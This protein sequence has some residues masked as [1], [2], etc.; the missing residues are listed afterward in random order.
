MKD[1][2]AYDAGYHPAAPVVP[3]GLSPSGIDTVHQQLTA[4]LDTGADATMIPL[5]VLNEAGCRYVAQK[6]LRGVIG[7]ATV[8]LYLAA[9][10]IAGTTVHG[11]RIVAMQG[12]S[13]AILGRDV[14]NQLELTLHGPA[15]ELWIH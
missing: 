13:E 11:L 14:I 12:S 4:M 8:S 9:I 6:R 1:I 10:H 7:V 2:I 5:A 15:Q 3:I